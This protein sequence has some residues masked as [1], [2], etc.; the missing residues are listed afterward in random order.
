MTCCATCGQ[1]L[2]PMVDGQSWADRAFA[3]IAEQLRLTREMLD[4]QR[5]TAR[6]VFGR[7]VFVW[8]MV[9]YRPD[10]SDHSIGKLLGDRDAKT[11]WHH[12]HKL[13]DLR[14]RN[15]DFNELCERF[16]AR[17]PLEEMSDGGT[18]H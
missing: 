17:H 13:D 3:F 14:R 16:A 2:P 11:V 12:R 7:Q 10:L 18:R 5:R 15:P 1:P 9:T 6:V 8:I 4:G